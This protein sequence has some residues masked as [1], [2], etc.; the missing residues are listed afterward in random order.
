MGSATSDQRARTSELR[1]YFG[2]R[3]FACLSA[4]ARASQSNSIKPLQWVLFSTIDWIGWGFPFPRP[5]K[6]YNFA[7]LIVIGIGKLRSQSSS[8]VAL[9]RFEIWLPRFFGARR[10]NLA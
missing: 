2:T 7:P 8:L 4:L 9:F 6:W 3:G 5:P 1:A 10:S